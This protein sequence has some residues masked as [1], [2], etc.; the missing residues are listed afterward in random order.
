MAKFERVEEIDVTPD[1]VWKVIITPDVWDEW[2]PGITGISGAGPAVVG[3]SYPYQAGDKTGKATVTRLEPG[4]MLE[5]V[6]EVGGHKTTH[7]FTL[8]PRTGGLLGLG[9]VNG[10]KVDYVMEYAPCLLYTSPSPRD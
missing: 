5:I 1:K 2:M 6:T 4:R 10:T 8:S 3:S 7:H 9:G